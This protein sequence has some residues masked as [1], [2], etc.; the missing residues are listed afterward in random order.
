VNGLEY[1]LATGP[2]S[3]LWSIIDTR[4]ILTPSMVGHQGTNSPTCRWN[5]TTHPL[6]KDGLNI[7]ILSF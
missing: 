5:S 7:V 3:M 1:A 6:G 2:I 4:G